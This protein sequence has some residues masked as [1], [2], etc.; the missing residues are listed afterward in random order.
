MLD[1]GL[2]AA[3]DVAVA[4]AV[5]EWITA[6][7]TVVGLIAAA[8]AAYFAFRAFR[9]EQNRDE[10]ADAA[11]FTPWW[12]VRVSMSDNGTET[13]IWGL[14]LTNS[15]ER[16]LRSVRVDTTVKQRGDSDTRVPVVFE[17]AYL[18]PGQYFM[19]SRRDSTGYPKELRPDEPRPEPLAKRNTHSVIS[20]QLRD[21]RGTV[22]EWAEEHG[23]RRA[24]RRR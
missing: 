3:A 19:E 15:S 20:Y 17:M 8:V 2:A 10:R 14:V 23:L 6:G 13:K 7:A 16:V 24:R 1:F 11:G 22:W 21:S 4:V 9:L 12:A 5:P 18:P